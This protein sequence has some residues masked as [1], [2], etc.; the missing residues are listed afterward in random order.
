[1]ESL[2]YVEL[3]VCDG[4]GAERARELITIARSQPWTD[5]RVIAIANADAYEPE[6]F[7]VLLKTLEETPS[8][9][10]FVLLARDLKGI[11]LAGQSRCVIYRLRPLGPAEAKQQARA[12]FDSHTIV[13]DERV[14]DVLVAMSQGMPAMPLSAYCRAR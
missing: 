7:D 5:R 9:T 1:M 10:T 8:A 3:D 2:G 4:R 13:Y 14:L 11:R 6:A 12:L